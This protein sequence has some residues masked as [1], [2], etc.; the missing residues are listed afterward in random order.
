MRKQQ[1]IHPLFILIVAS[2]Q[3]EE[4]DTTMDW[5]I[6]PP[7]KKYSDFIDVTKMSSDL[8]KYNNRFTHEFIQKSFQGNITEQEWL[9]VI[10]EIATIQDIS[11]SGLNLFER[12]KE[13]ISL[14]R[15]GKIT[16]DTEAEYKMIRNIATLYEKNVSLFLQVREFSNWLSQPNK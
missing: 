2:I 10:D 9:P 12:S 14:H 4:S 8:I 6:L 15:I 1:T 3:N 7:G 16:P 13:L 11:T 5:K